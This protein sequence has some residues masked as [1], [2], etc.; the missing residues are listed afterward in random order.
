MRDITICEFFGWD[1]KTL[2][3][4]SAKRID[5]FLIVIT[6]RRKRQIAQ[7]DK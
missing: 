7:G 3:S 4:Q 2:Y 6:E 1:L 5:E